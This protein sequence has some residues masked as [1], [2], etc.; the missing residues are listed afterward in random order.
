MS[1]QKLDIYHVRNLTQATLYPAKKINL[2]YGNNASG[3]SSIL[4]AIHL[5]GRANSFRS[6]TVKNVIQLTYNEL[7]V[8]GK[9]RFSNS[10]VSTL[11][12]QHDGKNL[13]IRIDEET[14]YARSDLAYALPIQ[15][16]HP[17]SYQLIDAGPQLRREFID[18]GVFNQHPDFLNNWRHFKKALNHRNALLKTR[19]VIELNVWNH[20]L[21]QYGTIVAEYRKQYL[22]EL[23]PFF[24]T[25]TQQFLEL[26]NLEL[27]LL[28]GWDE[29][30][31]LLDKLIED[32]EKD[33]R[34]GFTHSGPHRADFQLMYESRKAKDFVSRGQ[35][36]LLVLSLKL[37]QVEHLLSNGF[38]SGC[39]LIDDAV[40]E[41]DFTSRT[42]LLEFLEAMDV[43]VFMTA[44]E[45]NEFGDVGQHK[46]FHVKHGVV[47]ED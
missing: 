46:M 38:H 3:K 7:T 21:Q 44:T 8:S 40:A 9:V 37:A 13:Q 36:K 23:T 17:K 2:I 10:H 41:L 12:I 47:T 39:V 28:Q 26:E 24:L 27:K 43:Q 29:E 31:L 14:R 1:L 16:I 45:K 25:I 30:S 32:Q 22:A 5:L 20:E 35:L 6:T 15:L 19:R 33:L 34:Y 4:E 18:W 42:K 11:G